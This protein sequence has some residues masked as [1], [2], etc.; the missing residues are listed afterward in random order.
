[1]SINRDTIINIS[2]A[3]TSFSM[4]DILSAFTFSPLMVP[5][6][7]MVALVSRPTIDAIRNP[8]QDEVRLVAMMKFFPANAPAFNS[9]KI[10]TPFLSRAKERFRRA[11]QVQS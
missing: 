10:G 5:S 1:M 2:I 7:S 9:E 6:I 4:F 11:A 3:Q 8:Q